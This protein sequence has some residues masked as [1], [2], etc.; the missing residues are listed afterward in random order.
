MASFMATKS[1]IWRPFTQHQTAAAPL[2]MVSGDGAVL[3]AADGKSYLDLTSSWW[4][5]IHGHCHPKIAAAIAAQA[6]T[7]EHALAA[8]C[9]TDAAERLATRLGEIG[10]S[11]RVFFSDNGSTAVE[12]A[13]KLA[14]Q[15][16]QNREITHRT[17]FISFDGGYH[18]DTLAALSAGF[19]SGFY[20]KFADFRLDNFEFAP[21]PF[22]WLGDNLAEEKERRALKVL[23]QLLKPD[24]NGKEVAAVIIEPLIQ[25]AAGMRICSG[26]FTAAAVKLA[27]KSGALVIF[28]EVMTGFGRSG[29]MFAQQQLPADARPDLTCL[30]KGLSGGFLPMGATLCREELFSQF[31]GGDFDSAFAHGH[32]YTANPIAA[33]AAN[34]S[35]AIFAEENTLEKVAAIGKIHQKYLPRT[36]QLGA[37]RLRRLGAVAAFDLEWDSAAAPNSKQ[38]AEYGGEL[39]LALKRAFYAKGLLLRPLANTVYLLP[40]YSI[41]AEQLEDGWRGVLEVLADFQG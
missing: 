4:V 20:R 22:S 31:L 23:G 1:R 40:P 36:I 39:S 24:R 34:A 37:V 9:T 29:T 8:D 17:R 6:K 11:E 33:A 5:T 41:T 21:Y 12:V 28:D 10:G 2:K 26:E 3:T 16:W 25:A 32:S 18:G 30:A 13:L 7:L 27:R 15:Y 14:W 19:S 38:T 35:L